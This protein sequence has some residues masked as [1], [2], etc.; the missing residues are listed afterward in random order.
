M[1]SKSLFETPTKIRVASDDE[2]EFRGSLM[3]VHP[4]RAQAKP[5]ELPRR[6]FLIG[7][8]VETDL[9]IDD[10]LVSREHAVVEPRAGR[11]I[12]T[13]LDSTNGTFVN[14][15]RI[16]EW[17]LE[18]GDIIR[19]GRHIVKF[20]ACDN[21]EICFHET[22]YAMMTRDSL[23]GVHNRR[24][25]VESLQRELKR[26]RRRQRALCLILL[27][28]DHLSEINDQHGYLAGDMVLREVMGR[29]RTRLREEEVLARMGGGEFGICLPEATLEEARLA[30]ERIRHL[31]EEAPV[32]TDTDLLPVTVSLG[33]AVAR[34]DEEVDAEALILRGE[35]KVRAAKSSGRNRVAE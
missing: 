21:I 23:T 8:G 31:V 15:R 24:F 7:R 6:R 17:E 29:F 2:V 16:H 26:C 3:P 18:D 4:P 20:L 13:D 34:P 1:Q 12:L 5:V 9:Q 25:F 10:T 19:F 30:A 22:M 35:E 11:F 14:G 33:L 27:D 32:A 28:F